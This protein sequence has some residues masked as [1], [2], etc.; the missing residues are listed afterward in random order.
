MHPLRQQMI[1]ALTSFDQALPKLSSQV[2]ILDKKG[3]W[4]S[5]TPLISQP[6][7][8]NLRKLKTEITKRRGV[9]SWSRY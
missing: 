4:I 1:D 7:P 6:E 2:R 8:Q 9:T 3:D 5:L